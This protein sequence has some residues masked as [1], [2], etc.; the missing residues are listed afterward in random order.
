MKGSDVG[1]R[2]V[3]EPADL[4]DAL[5]I[6][7][8]AHAEQFDKVG[9]PY[10]MHPLRMVNEALGRGC[11][12][13]V[14]IVA[15]L[16]DVVEDS[17]L[18][19]DDLRASGFSAAVIEALDAVTKRNGESYEAFIDRCNAAS[20][21]ARCVKLLD[22]ADN[23]EPSRMRYLPPETRARLSAKYYAARAKLETPAPFSKSLGTLADAHQNPP[24]A[25]HHEP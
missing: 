11:H 24:E 5:L 9:L 22:L 7:A 12:P 23:L 21:V 4:A 10:L 1:I 14:A 15:A 17:C 3:Q 19:L 13:N 6:A 16:H 25:E 20:A 8:K 2:E 18:T